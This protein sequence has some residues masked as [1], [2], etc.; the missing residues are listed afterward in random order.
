MRVCRRGRAL[1]LRRAVAKPLPKRYD[2]SWDARTRRMMNRFDGPA[3]RPASQTSLDAA[4]L[5]SRALLCSYEY[6]GR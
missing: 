3:P 4:V 1:A 2:T 6:G 5:S